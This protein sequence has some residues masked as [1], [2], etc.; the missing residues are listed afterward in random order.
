[1]NLRLLNYQ[2]RKRTFFKGDCGGGGHHHAA[3]GDGMADA[4]TFKAST[5]SESSVTSA[6]MVD[7]AS[8]ENKDSL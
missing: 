4:A 7:R 3:H 8:F 2:L 1:M 6:E 5:T